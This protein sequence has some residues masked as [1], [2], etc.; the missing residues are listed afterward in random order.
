MYSVTDHGAG[1]ADN[2]RYGLE[3]GQ[4]Q[5]AEYANCRNDGSIFSEFFALVHWSSPRSLI[6]VISF[7]GYFGD[8]DKIIWHHDHKAKE[9]S[10]Q[11]APVH[12][13]LAE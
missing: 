6:L 4:Y 2:T 1:M 9:P 12:I 7:S 11:I 8:F 10:D 3:N 5:V 13:I